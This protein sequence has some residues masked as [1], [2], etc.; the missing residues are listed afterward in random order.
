MTSDAEPLDPAQR[1]TLRLF[2]AGMTPTARI[3]L[4]NLESIC[5]EHLAG[6]F[7]L[8]VV[9]LREHPE[10][11]EEEQILAVPTLIRRLPPPLRKVIGDLSDREKVIRGLDLLPEV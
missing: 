10:Q 2:V 5:E 4:R 7:T 3:A 8:E 1:F 6:R 9:D 11:A